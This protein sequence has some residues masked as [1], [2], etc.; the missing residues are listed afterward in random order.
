MPDWYPLMRAARWMRVAPW[1]LLK[2]PAVWQTWA[3]ESEKIDAEVQDELAKQN[4]PS[5]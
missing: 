4:A 3:L 5:T 1:D 2:Q